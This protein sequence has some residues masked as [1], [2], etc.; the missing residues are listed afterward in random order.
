MGELK[1]GRKIQQNTTII[2]MA[3]ESRLSLETEFIMETAVNHADRVYALIDGGEY[4]ISYMPYD[5]KEYI[6]TVLAGGEL[7]TEFSIDGK[8][9]GVE[10]GQYAAIVIMNYYKENVL[11]VPANAVYKD[12]N[13]SYVYK[14]EDGQRTRCDV[15]VGTITDVKAEILDGLEK[16]EMVY[17]KE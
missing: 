10:C 9:D 16:G 15:A 8:A 7:T 2:C 11:T 1:T 14:V 17:V 5:R 12:Q 13:G 3:D 4:D 6:T